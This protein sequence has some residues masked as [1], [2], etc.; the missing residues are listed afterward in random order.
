MRAQVLVSDAKVSV[1]QPNTAEKTAEKTPYSA[2]KAFVIGDAR[3][4]LLGGGRHKNDDT[5]RPGI[6]VE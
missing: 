4:L 1:N 2:P 3:Q 5:G 6:Y